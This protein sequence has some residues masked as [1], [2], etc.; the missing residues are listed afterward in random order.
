M[1]SHLNHH[2][3]FSDNQ[4][5]FMGG[6]PT[7]LQLLKVLDHWTEILDHGGSVDCIYMDF[8]KAFN[9]VP[10][11]RLLHKLKRYGINGNAVNWITAFLTDRRQRIQVNGTYSDWATVLSGI[12]QG[13]VLG[14]LLFVIYIND[15]PDI[16]KNSITY[17][18]ADDTKIYKE[19]RGR[20][21]CDALQ[22]DLRA[23]QEWSNKWL[24]KFHPDKC[25]VLSLK[26]WIKKNTATSYIIP[27][28][29]RFHTTLK[30]V[31]S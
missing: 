19:V 24:L 5:G 13:S 18:F 6:C 4:Y 9:K 7:T 21:D 25:K 26:T 20:N 10:H 16:P 30:K 17:L 2:N 11:K 23:L 29:K 1:V 27:P 12:P 22:E 28:L 31:P 14:P 8:M 15:L 3:L